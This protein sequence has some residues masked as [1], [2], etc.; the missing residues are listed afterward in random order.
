MAW[1]GYL[2]VSKVSEAGESEHEQRESVE[3]WARLRKVELLDPVDKDL[4]VPGSTLSRPGLDKV[5]ADIEGGR[6]QGIV[7]AK[8]S[9][10]SRAGVVDALGLIERIHAAGGQIVSVEE[11]ID[12]TTSFG[13][14]TMTVLLALNRMEL[15]RIQEGWLM[16]RQRAVSAGKFVGPTPLGFDRVEGRLVLNADAPLVAEAFAASANDGFDAAMGFCR[17]TWPGR[18]WTAT[19][20]RN[21]LA[22]RVYRGE[23][24]SGEFSAADVVPR[25]VDDLTWMM[26]QHPARGRKPDRAYPLSK[27]ATCA[28]C[29]GGLVGYRAGEQHRRGYRCT[30][31]SC[32]AKVHLY[33]E[34]LELIALEALRRAVARPRRPSRKDLA[35]AIQDPS[36]GGPAHDLVATGLEAVREMRVAQEEL[37]RYVAETSVA[38]LGREL[39]HHGLTERK[40]RLTAA[41]HSAQEIRRAQ[42]EMPDLDAPTLEEQRTIF[43]RSIKSLIVAQGRRVPLEQRVALTL[44]K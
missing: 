26:A 6:S 7:V 37:E 31:P 39:W 22:Q 36:L 1:S 33:S 11:G 4:D 43:E 19:T 41:Q 34:P 14:F 40:D 20:T 29:G 30:N 23:S 32:S 42:D 12:P 5:L 28:A 2:R 13:K 35:N 21:L 10:L 3:Q 24:V 38:E 44:V 15:E 9:R 18:T 25:V 27:I 16:R 17:T 8:L